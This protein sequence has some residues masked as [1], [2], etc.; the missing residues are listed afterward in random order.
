MRILFAGTPFF[1]AEALNLLIKEKFDVAMVLSQPDRPAGRG[2]KLKMSEV[3][4]LALGNG[5]QVE[6]PLTLSK[7]KGG[8]EVNDLYKRIRSLDIDLFVVAAYGLILPKEFLDIPKGILPEKFPTLKAVNIHGSLLPKW[9]GAAPI[10]RA[11]EAGD[12]ETGITLMQMDVGLDTGPMLFKKAIPIEESDTAGSLTQKMASLGARM[13]IE[14][15]RNPCDYPPQPQPDTGTYAS[16]INKKEGKIDWN[17]QAKTIANKIRAFNPAPGC[18][19]QYEN[20]NIKI[21]MAFED[22]TQSKEM[23]GTILKS[24]PSGIYVACG[25]HSVIKITELQKP[26]GRRLGVK[27]FLLGNSIEKGKSFR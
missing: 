14:Y 1:A 3:K 19:S 8:E 12:N 9:R 4:A 23:P 26:G 15:L 24:E 27:E 22:G 11:I 16:K 20:E 21:W 2:R 18:L 6:T 5:I 7:K 25:Q 13:L 17:L 10:A